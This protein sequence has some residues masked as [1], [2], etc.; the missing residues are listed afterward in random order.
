MKEE[1]ENLQR[2]ALRRARQSHRRVHRGVQRAMDQR[3]SE[4]QRQILQLFQHRLSAQAGAKAG[5]SRSGSAAIASRR[6]A[7]PR[8]SATAG[9]PS[10][11]C[12]RFRWSQR[13]SPQICR[14]YA[15]TRE[16]AGRDPET[17]SRRAER[18]ALRPRKTNHSWQRRRFMGTRRRDRLR[19]P[20]L[21]GRRRR[22]D[23]LRRAPAEHRRNPGA[24]GVDGEGSISPGLVRVFK[25]R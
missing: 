5:D 19:H 7:A 22:H 9:I 13:T 2:R 12:R 14:C 4:L 8:A 23:D 21:S 10:A 24:D 3:Q 20:R 17:N 15:N 16:K 11:A 25:D 18:L 6:S 1:F